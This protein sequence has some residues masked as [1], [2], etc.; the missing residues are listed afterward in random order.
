[1]KLIATIY[2]LTGFDFVESNFF[3]ILRVPRK[4]LARFVFIVH[5]VYVCCNLKIQYYFQVEL[6][7]HPDI[8]GNITNLVEMVLPLLCH[9]TLVCESF[10][11]RAKEEEIRKLMKKI[12]SA[13]NC[14]SRFSLMSLPIVK[15]L[16]LF[17]VNSLIYVV[18][19]VM[20]LRVVGEKWSE[21][22]VTCSTRVIDSTDI[23]SRHRSQFKTQ[24][25]FVRL[26]KF[27]A[28]AQLKKP[29]IRFSPVWRLNLMLVLPSAVLVNLFDFYFASR[30]HFIE[31]SS[32]LIR[33]GLICAADSEEG[34]ALTQ[35][36]ETAIDLWHV[37]ELLNERFSFTLLVS[38]TSKLAILVVDFYWQYIRVSRSTFGYYFIR[39][40]QC[41]CSLLLVFHL[42]IP[43][44]VVHFVLSSARFANWSF[45]LL[46]FG[47]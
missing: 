43:R 3:T 13:L 31:R 20:V 26:I 9:L 17:V 46:Q 6:F 4:F 30:V 38:I 27:R 37:T 42:F 36:K 40:K 34:E 32:I 7:K 10:Y 45:L 15:F 41:K 28:L 33:K 1:M 23:K 21:R 25:A 39:K 11:K 12:Q 16:F 44:S 18:V 24:Q 5:F 8:T 19:L 47:S 29:F 2:Q 35:M 14:S 22:D